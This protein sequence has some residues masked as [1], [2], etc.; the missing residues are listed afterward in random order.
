MDRYTKYIHKL[1]DTELYQLLYRYQ[2]KNTNKAEEVLSYHHIIILIM[3]MH[4]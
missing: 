4:I 2:F 1:S 3:V